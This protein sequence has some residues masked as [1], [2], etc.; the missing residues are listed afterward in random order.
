MLLIQRS[1]NWPPSGGSTSVQVGDAAVPLAVRCSSPSL[2]AAH[3]MSELPCAICTIEWLQNGLS[4]KWS[5]GIGTSDGQLRGAL[6]C[7][8]VGG[9][10]VFT[11]S[12]RHNERPPA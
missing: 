3:T 7:T 11:L 9:L 10:P 5:V 2:C 12:V 8:H 6:I 4:A 1:G